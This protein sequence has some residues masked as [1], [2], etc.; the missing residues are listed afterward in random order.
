MK[1]EISINTKTE[2]SVLRGFIVKIFPGDKNSRR[3]ALFLAFLL[4]F[5]GTKLEAGGSKRG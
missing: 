3:Q 5:T 4:S 1:G 2:A